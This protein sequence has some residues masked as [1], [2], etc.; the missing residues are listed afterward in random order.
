[1]FS[2]LLH[3]KM[4]RKYQRKSTRATNYTP[5][6][7]KEALL[8]IPQSTLSAHK[9]GVRGKKSRTMGRGTAI[10]AEDEL[11]LVECISSMEKWGWGL[12][13]GE[14]LRIVGEYCIK[15]RFKIPFKN[16]YPGE[17]WFLGFARRHK[18]SIKKPQSV[19]VVHT[20]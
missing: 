5:D 4:V 12:T 11:K 7:L 1:M 20:E 8:C 13:R 6:K 17:D 10:S 16:S 19:T 15:N 3:K 9:R 18:L 2:G 14:I